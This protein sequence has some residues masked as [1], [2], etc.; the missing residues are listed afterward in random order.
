M[1]KT[2]LILFW[3]FWLLD[4]LIALF[5]YR[6]FMFGLFGRNATPSSKY[7]SIWLTLLAVATLIIGGSLYF[8]N[9]GHSTTALYVAA[10][11][12]VLALPYLLWMA[13][14]LLSGKNTRWN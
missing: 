3:I 14:I 4:V 1:T 13:V 5:G 12:L 6:E 2:T 11:P 9:Q 8:K 10:T 7:I